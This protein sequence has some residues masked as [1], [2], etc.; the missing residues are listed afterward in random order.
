MSGNDQMTCRICGGTQTINKRKHAIE[1]EYCHN[2]TSVP[3]HSDEYGDLFE[4]ANQLRRKNEFDQAAHLY[5]EL[6]KSDSGNA[7]AHYELALCRHGIEYVQDP[8]TGKYIPTCHR[9]LKDKFFINDPDYLEALKYSEDAEEKQAYVD[10]ADDINRV[11]QGILAES[12]RMNPY[13]IFISFKDTEE[14]TERRTEAS[15]LAE[16][17]YHRLMAEGYTVFFSRETLKKHYGQ[18]YEAVIFSALQTA[19]AMILIGTEKSHFTAP[20]VRNEWSRYLELIGSGEP[21]VLLPA[22][23][24]LKPDDLPHEISRLQAFDLGRKTAMDEIADYVSERLNRR[25]NLDR[26]RDLLAIGGHEREAKEII[27]EAISLDPRCSKA[28]LLRAILEMG[29]RLESQIPSC[30]DKLKSLR[31]N[32]SFQAALRYATDAEKKPLK[33]LLAENT[34]CYNRAVQ[35]AIDEN[36]RK[37][38]ER[39]KEEDAKRKFDRLCA[40]RNAFLARQNSA[41][42]RLGNFI[43]FLACLAYLAMLVPVTL[44]SLGYFS[45]LPLAVYSL[46]KQIID[47]FVLITYRLPPWVPAVFPWGQHVCMLLGSALLL[48]VGLPFG[49]YVFRRAASVSLLILIAGAAAVLLSHISF[50]DYNYLLPALYIAGFLLSVRIVCAI[51]GSHR[52]KMPRAPVAL[53]HDKTGGVV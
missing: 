48:A 15:F 17:V 29:Y 32:P 16:K 53:T 24:S 49:Y 50:L 28:Y 18:S 27:D 38:L 43:L 11:Q 7:A 5:E 36:D 40:R 34:A 39:V 30:G 4:A 42:T 26:A 41:F 6:L 25:R 19:R 45:Q 9:M 8:K 35:R 10:Q 51:Y 1:C 46:L 13:Q 31:D 3:G 44:H 20:W 22:Y 47:L 52:V 14:D 21:K 23:K 37:E 12:A 33:K 2:M